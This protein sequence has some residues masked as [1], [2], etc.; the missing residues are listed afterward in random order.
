MNTCTDVCCLLTC[1]IWRQ[2]TMVRQTYTVI[3]AALQLTMLTVLVHTDSLEHI[4][5]L[6]SRKLI[7]NN[8]WMRHAWWTN[9]HHLCTEF[10]TRR[11]VTVAFIYIYITYIHNLID[12]TY[13]Y[14]VILIVCW[15]YMCHS[16]ET[17]FDW[18][19]KDFVP[20]MFHFL[21][22]YLHTR[23]PEQ[24]TLRC[25]RWTSDLRLST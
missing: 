14:I 10:K 23:L 16:K 20:L 8:V 19:M 17:Q 13:W 4:A 11:K 9:H 21:C 3:T 1:N 12:A 18:F 2:L 22:S 25:Q 6:V 24:R 5:R 15:K 7:L